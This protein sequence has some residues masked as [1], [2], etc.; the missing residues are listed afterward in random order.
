MRGAGRWTRENESLCSAGKK[1]E[2][3][4]RDTCTCLATIAPL[5][6][7][8]SAAVGPAIIIRTTSAAYSARCKLHAVD[9]AC[10]VR[11]L[12]AFIIYQYKYNH[13]FALVYCFCLSVNVLQNKN[14]AKM[15]LLPE[16]LC[17]LYVGTD[18]SATI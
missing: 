11:R 9:N 3:A 17:S 1:C 18:H 5:M 16:S 8:A 10:P 14:S 15:L 12:R 7:A 13:L 2:G 6:V 4:A